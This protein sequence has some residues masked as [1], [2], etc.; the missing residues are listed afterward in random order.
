MKKLYSFL[1][2]VMAS[3]LFGLD[4]PLKEGDLA[5]WEPL[6]FPKIPQHSEYSI[7]Q[8]GG[9]DVLQIVTDQS[10]SGLIYPGD[11]DPY[12]TPYVSWSWFAENTFSAGDARQK[13]GDDYPVRIYI[14]FPYDPETASFRERIMYNAA[15]VIYGE[16]PPLGSLNYV[17]AN[18]E[19]EGFF[20]NPFTDRAMMFPL[21]RG[22]EDTGQW[23]SWSVNILE[24]YQKAFGKMPPPR[25]RIAIMGDSDNTGEASRAYL[26]NLKVGDKP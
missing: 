12:K 10:A 19:Q 3:G 14:L 20:P 16:Y 25:A 23:Q 5:L 1:F 21:G 8:K 18:R 24:D 4:L 9:G 15:R 17:F 7:V 13:G 26:R 2:I 6:T 11:F 22:G